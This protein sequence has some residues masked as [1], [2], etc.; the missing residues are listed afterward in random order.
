MLS[1]NQSR[2]GSKLSRRLLVYWPLF[3]MALLFAV[4]TLRVGIRFGDD[5]N[6]LGACTAKGFNTFQYLYQTYLTWS[7]RMPSYFILVTLLKVNLMYWRAF[8]TLVYII[9]AYSIFN[10]ALSEENKI[11]YQKKMFLVLLVSIS[12]FGIYASTFSTS[13][14]WIS[15]SIVYFW[16]ITLGLFA[17]IPYKNAIYREKTST[18]IFILSWLGAFYG[19]YCEQMAAALILFAFVA[20]FLIRII[21]KEKISN[22]LIALTSWIV[23]N[24]VISFAAPG[25]QI[26]FIG[27]VKTWFPGF[28]QLSFGA[29]LL[30]GNAYLLL[31]FF[32]HLP[33]LIFAISSISAILAFRNSKRLVNRIIF[34]LP[35]I[36]FLIAVINFVFKLQI[37]P[38]GLYMPL[39]E[40]GRGYSISETRSL[41]LILEFAPFFLFLGYSL[42]FAAKSLERRV[43]LLAL[44]VCALLTAMMMSF[45]PTIF[46]SGTR[47]FFISEILFVVVF[48]SLLVETLKEKINLKTAILAS[49]PIIFFIVFCLI[50][51]LNYL[52][53]FDLR[54]F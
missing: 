37:I 11:T 35:V 30:Q 5:S 33:A 16:P 41:K 3:L 19:A 46:G 39:V 52:E 22:K 40:G 23:F 47:V 43:F 38:L 2:C 28:D 29:R 13:V 25:N 24:G 34:L 42:Y 54:Y 44:Y 45:S 18:F 21:R 51:L 9:L 31:H 15:G 14:Q 1:K 49:I 36:I 50:N 12:I 53:R 48:V 17:L 26:R 6:L 20:F 7:G 10:L 8:N 4:I 27:E 32:A